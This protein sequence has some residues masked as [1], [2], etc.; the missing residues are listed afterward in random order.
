MSS[1]NNN[2]G[3]WNSSAF[4]GTMGILGTL[5]AVVIIIMV[6]AKVLFVSD[7]SAE[8]K[9]TGRITSTEPKSVSTT[10]SVKTT[11]KTVKKTSRTFN[12]YDSIDPEDVDTD[13]YTT[14]RVVSAVYLHPQPTSASENLCVIPVGAVCK[15]FKNEN[16]WLYLDYNGQ[17]GYAY[18]TFFTE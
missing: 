17:K 10:V 1:K 4:K 16:G 3:F 11:K 13:E 15:V 12:N 2:S 6:C 9:K 7:V 5:L 18:Y 14:Q 8:N